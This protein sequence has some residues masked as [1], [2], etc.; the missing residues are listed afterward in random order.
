MAPAGGRAAGNGGRRMASVKKRE[1]RPLPWYVYWREPGTTKQ[2]AR[3]FKTKQP[4]YGTRSYG[5]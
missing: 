5:M 1:D 4:P 3:A 2:Q